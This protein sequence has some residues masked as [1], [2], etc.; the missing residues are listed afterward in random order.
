M[1]LATFIVEETSYGMQR[2]ALSPAF[3]HQSLVGFR[4][5]NPRPALHE[6]HPP[7]Y[8]ESLGVAPTD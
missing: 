2:L 6:Q 7:L 8:T 1:W 5:L 3:P 4:V